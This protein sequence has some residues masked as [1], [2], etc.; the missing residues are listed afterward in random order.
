[1]RKRNINKRIKQWILSTTKAVHMNINLKT[2]NTGVNM[3]YDFIHHFLGCDLSRVQK[4]RNSMKKPISLE[5]YIKA[6]TMHELGHAMDRE[7][8]LKSLPKTIEIFKMRRYHSES[9]YRNN[10]QLF[11]MIIEEHEMNIEF[12]ETAWRNAEI[13]NRIYGI[14]NWEDFYNVK[15]HSLATY[16]TLYTSDLL[17]YNN[18]VME[19]N[20]QT[21][22]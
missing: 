5:T 7:A 16:R 3:S 8:L 6:L 9:E 2:E 18:I 21:A 22:S 20:R 17:H 4:A 10:G 19:E 12:E 11:Q 1:M 14:V 13:L 15:E